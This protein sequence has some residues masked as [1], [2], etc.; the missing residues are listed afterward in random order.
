MA[1]TTFSNGTVVVPEWLNEANG[2]VHKDV[3]NIKNTPYS[4]VGNGVID[5]TAAI[6]AAIDAIASDGTI[7]FPAG[8]YLVTNELIIPAG[9]SVSL[10]GYSRSNTTIN[11]VLTSLDASKYVVRYNGTAG[12]ECEYVTIKDLT[13]NARFFGK[14]VYASYCYPKFTMQ[15]V[16]VWKP[17]N[18][19]VYLNECWGASLIDVSVD[20]DNASD[21]NAF[22]I[23]NANAVSLYNPRVYNMKNSVQSRAIYATSAECFNI[24]GGNIENCPRG[25]HVTGVA[26]FDGPITIQGVYFEP[27]GM[28]PWDAGQ[29]NDHILLE[30]DTSGRGAAYI[31]GCLF[32][33]GNS[34]IPIAYNAVTARNMGVVSLQGNT[35]QKAAYAAG[36]GTNFFVDADAT[37]GKIIQTGNQ[38]IS[39]SLGNLNTISASVLLYVNNIN[40]SGT[41]WAAASGWT[42][43]RVVDTGVPTATLNRDAVAGGSAGIGDID[44][45]AREDATVYASGGRISAVADGAWTTSNHGTDLLFYTTPNGSTTLTQ[46]LQLE[47]GGTVQPGADN[48][49]SFGTSSLR[50]SQTYSLELRPGA[51]AVIWTSGTGTPEAA[52]TA[53]VGSLYTRSDGGATTTLYV[54]ESGSGNTG[55][56]AK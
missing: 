39:T 32:Q 45:G 41:N 53:P 3:I 19:G 55:W 13:I 14:G 24:F 11:G 15:N 30:G 23:V 54:K 18:D 4:A 44:F 47:A 38:L 5:D 52:V 17:G 43:V 26:T 48:T 51:G 27:R 34:G 33:A 1:D 7:M 12:T 56:V 36:A 49:Q 10:V 31:S 8:T 37:V 6:Q 22:Y 28:Q 21:G 29:P 25:I 20:G 40:D 42:S 2:R 46:R 35:W 50:W 9:K 16:H